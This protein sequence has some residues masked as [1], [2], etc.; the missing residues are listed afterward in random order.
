MRQEHLKRQKACKGFC[1]SK[2]LMSEP[3]PSRAKELQAMIRPKIKGTFYVCCSIITI[4]VI[5]KVD[6][7]STDH[8]NYLPIHKTHHTVLKCNPFSEAN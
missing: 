7:G 6:V 2:V 3:Q 4:F 8:L 1:Q 5:L